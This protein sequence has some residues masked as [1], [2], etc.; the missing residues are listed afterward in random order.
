MPPGTWHLYCLRTVGS[1]G[2]LE[3]VGSAYLD[4]GELKSG[5]VINVNADSYRV[6][7]FVH[8]NLENP[9]DLVVVPA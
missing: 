9:G 8:P 2:S 3:E 5:D 6:V 1:T 4:G 7:F